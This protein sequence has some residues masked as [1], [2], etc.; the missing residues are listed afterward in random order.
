MEQANVAAEGTAS[1]LSEHFE[2]ELLSGA[3]DDEDEGA[4]GGEDDL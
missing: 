4:R 2:G 3:V 1:A